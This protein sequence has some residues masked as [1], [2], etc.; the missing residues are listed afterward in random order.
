M[1]N[2]SYRVLITG[3]GASG[4][5]C[6]CRLILGGISDIIILEKN[7][8]P[9]SKLIMTGN[10]R[11]NLSNSS[12]T[13]D[14]YNTD[15]PDI[16][17][18]LFDLYPGEK[19]MSFINNDL[20][21]MTVSNGDLIYPSTYQSNT[22]ARAL[23]RIIED[24]GVEILYETPAVSIVRD[25]DS[26]IINDTFRADNVVVCTGGCSYPVTGS[27]GNGF[28]L[29]LPFFDKTDFVPVRPSL[30][31]L[32][33]KE[34]DIRIL[35]GQRVK[36]QASLAGDDHVETGEMLFTDYGV[37]GIMIMQLS[38]RI[39][40]L[41]EGTGKAPV[42]NVD[43]LPAY[44]E[45]E[46]CG[47]IKDRYSRFPSRKRYECLEGIFSPAM[48]M[49]LISRYTDDPVKLAKGIKGFSLTVTGDQGFEHAQITSGGIKL[50]SAYNA[51]DKGLFAIGEAVNVDGPCG[52]Y[53]LHWAWLS[54][55][56]AA[57]RIRES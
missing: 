55:I 10:G 14:D 31:P 57:D 52:G 11:C 21:V 1:N 46:I 27:D 18:E 35:S 9:A 25:E 45:D 39:R 41:F 42:I 26:Y 37:S 15:S 23:L 29:L 44:S 13:S 48:S 53:N 34:D 28:R 50:G 33:T 6:A 22:V 2:K 30:V 16:L 56:A 5:I 36:C 49:V 54:G 43:I 20:G 24:A 19:I 12:V 17:K 38:G 8:K 51:W 40:S 4:L 7:K 47:M 32:K 3:A